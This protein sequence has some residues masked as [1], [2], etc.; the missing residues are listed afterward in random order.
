MIALISLFMILI[1]SIT[2]VRIGA[3]GLE[4]TGLS[5]EVA[6]F[7]SQSA[8]SGAGFTTTES[9]SIVTHPVRRKIIRRLI[10]IGSAG[11]TS[12]IATFVL[13]FSNA[14]GEGVALRSVLLVVGCILIYLLARSKIIYNIMKKAIIKALSLNKELKLYDY[15]EILGISKGYSITRMS[16]KKDNWA[17]GK[18]LKDLGLNEEGTLILSIH[19]D[20]NGEEKFIIPAGKTQ[21]E[22]GDRL[23]VFGKCTNSECLFHRPQG[24]EG[25]K[26][27]KIRSEVEKK[28]KEVEQLS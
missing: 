13:T 27:H 21:L 11:I 16:V 22:V 25:N 4:L 9:E 12:T 17:V 2:V 1:M 23:T 14:S 10:L 19:R 15:Q 5:T 7:Q 8:F 28:L 3:I 26:I 6:S 20:V 18:Q 24:D